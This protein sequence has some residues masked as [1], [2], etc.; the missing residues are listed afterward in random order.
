[1][2]VDRDF[3]FHVPKRSLI[4]R[5]S[6]PDDADGAAPG[7][8]AGR[9]V[10]RVIDRTVKRLLGSL[11]SLAGPLYTVGSHAGFLTGRQ[12]RVLEAL[13]AQCLITGPSLFLDPPFND[14]PKLFIVSLPPAIDAKRLHGA[15]FT[16]PF[17]YGASWDFDEAFSKGVGEFLERY[18][19]LFWRSYP[20]HHASRAE[21]TRRGVRCLDP[22]Q[23]VRLSEA[24][25]SHNG[26]KRMDERTPIRWV[27]GRRLF[28]GDPIWLPAQLVFWNYGAHES[29][30]PL[31]GEANTN[32]AGGMFTLRQAILSGLRELI[33]R[34]AFL[35]VWLNTA[36]PPR[37]DPSTLEG[38]IRELLALFARYRFELELLDITSDIGLPAFAAILLDVSGEGK[39]V[40]VAA[41]CEASPEAAIKRAIT[42]SLLIAHIT[43]KRGGTWSLPEPYEPFVT[44]L[45][46]QE[47]VRLWANPSMFERFRWFLEG[48]RVS[49][50]QVKERHQVPT[51]PEQELDWLIERFQRLGP[52]YEIYY[53]PVPHPVLRAVGYHVVKV[54][55]PALVPLYL[56]ERHAPL[57]CRRLQETP[58]K[59]GYREVAF[60]NPLPHPF[61]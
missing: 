8:A 55:V 17:S 5:A 59:L 16:G 24:Q 29:G 47:R 4:R 41:G 33:Q 42:E 36:A 35:T 56:L 2:E 50:V 61:G 3:E 28:G 23:V 48:P 1:M 32:G 40:Y 13:H 12:Q 30:E 49:F 53:Y 58:Q 44:P 46:Q 38:E 37:L 54:M 7:Y 15:A 11:E 51:D 31:L 43:R 60:P 34:D 52:G 26:S 9:P 57:A 22:R 14:E 25:Q 10:E 21:L 45:G 27:Q 18:T 19:L 39:G 6:S 20:S